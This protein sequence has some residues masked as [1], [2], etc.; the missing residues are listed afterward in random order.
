MVKIII[1]T[2]GNLGREV[3][4]TAESIVG[5][6]ENVLVLSMGSNSLTNV[7]FQTEEILK[8]VDPA[9]GALILTDMLGG[10]PCN[11]A[12]PYSDKYNI[13]IVSGINLYMLLSAF[14]HREAMPVSEL[15]QKVILDGR[16]NITNAKEIFLKNLNK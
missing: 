13:E 16:K 4:L 14:M 5:A 10:T 7:C 6:Q 9:Q 12:L 11:A 3:L 8:E 2:H 1:I 15:S